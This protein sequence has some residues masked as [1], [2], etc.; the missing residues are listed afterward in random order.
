MVNFSPWWA[1]QRPAFKPQR[2]TERRSQTFSVTVVLRGRF[3]CLC[4]IN[5]VFIILF[6]SV[7]TL[8]RILLP[9]SRPVLPPPHP[10]P[11]PS[12]TSGCCF[13]SRDEPQTS[14]WFITMESGSCEKLWV[15]CCRL[16]VQRRGRGVETRLRRR[17]A[18]WS[19]FQCQTERG[20]RTSFPLDLKF[21]HYFLCLWFHK[22]KQTAKRQPKAT[23]FSDA[24]TA[25]S[26]LVSLSAG[27]GLVQDPGNPFD[28]SRVFIA[29]HHP[30]HLHIFTF[31]TFDFSSSQE[32]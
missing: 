24:D 32:S 12:S 22:L 23:S 9:L 7:S 25:G 13:L 17:G 28:L 18:C 21:S 10:Q 4:K 6:I 8:R 19:W 26:P 15:Q 29:P 20:F 2:R 1:N 31:L 16:H 27:P 3:V 11:R 14:I 30:R 5:L